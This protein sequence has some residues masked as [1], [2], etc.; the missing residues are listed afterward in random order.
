MIKL[1]QQQELELPLGVPLVALELPLDLLVDPQ[2][3]GVF[4]GQAALLHGGPG[5]QAGRLAG[6]RVERRA[7]QRCSAFILPRAGSSSGAFLW[8]GGGGLMGRL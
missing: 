1:T 3:L 7:A 5:W 4:A 2:L 8:A 6:W